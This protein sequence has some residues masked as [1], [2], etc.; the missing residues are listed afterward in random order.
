MIIFVVYYKRP[1]DEQSSR[2]FIVTENESETDETIKRKFLYIY[3]PLK[4]DNDF[5]RFLLDFDAEYKDLIVVD[6]EFE[7]EF[8]TEEFEKEWEEYNKGKTKGK[9][10]QVPKLV[11][12]VPIVEN[13]IVKE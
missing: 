10:K 9:R 5:E 2:F 3:D 4:H 1:I 12:E 8:N 13:I 6:T 7:M 11:K